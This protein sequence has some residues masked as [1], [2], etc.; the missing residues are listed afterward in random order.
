[1]PLLKPVSQDDLPDLSYLIWFGEASVAL[2]SHPFADACL[3]EDMM[4]SP[5]SF[6]ESQPQQE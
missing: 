4:A 3:P 2:H 5:H 1:M 6:S